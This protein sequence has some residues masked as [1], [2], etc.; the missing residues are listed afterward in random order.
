MWE[1]NIQHSVVKIYENI[2]NGSR[3]G[4]IRHLSILETS[5]LALRDDPIK[6]GIFSSIELHICPN[7]LTAVPPEAMLLPMPA[8]AKP[9]LFPMV[10]IDWTPLAMALPIWVVFCSS[11]SSGALGSPGSTASAEVSVIS[12]GS[13]LSVSRGR[14]R[15]SRFLT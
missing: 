14:F 7:S 11:D 8:Q 5:Q 9:N 2:G 15:V 3:H 4:T 6:L 13:A 12:P 10:P 1:G